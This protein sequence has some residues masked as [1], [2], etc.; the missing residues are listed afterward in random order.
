MDEFHQKL[1]ERFDSKPKKVRFKISSSYSG[2]V[3]KQVYEDGQ[4]V[5]SPQQ[6]Y[7]HSF[8]HGKFQRRIDSDQFF[9]F[10]EMPDQ[11]V[12]TPTR[13]TAQR[14]SV[15]KDGSS[16]S[17]SNGGHP[18]FSDFTPGDSKQSSVLDFGKIIIYTS[19]LRIIRT[20][21]GKKE[22][23][24]QM[25]EERNAFGDDF[26]SPI[27]SDELQPSTLSED[28]NELYPKATY[29]QDLG[30]DSR[31]PQCEGRGCSPCAVCH[32]S[33][34]SMLANRFNESIKSLR[35]PACNVNGLQA[36][37]SCTA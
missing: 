27:A 14:I 35:C 31:C 9:S 12:Y 37:R 30:E 18:L 3:L 4:A 20:S 5:E 11:G 22:L 28:I 25:I 21:Q 16:Y 19:N 32:G 24:K 10:G 34:L 15:F 29:F 1:N 7:P 2:R 26:R 8:L 23:A 17:F 36:C 13:L 6:D 33:K